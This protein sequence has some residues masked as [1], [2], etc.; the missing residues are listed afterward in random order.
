MLLPPSRVR[1]AIM[2]LRNVEDRFNRRLGYPYVLFMVEGEFEELSEIDKK[3]IEWVTEGR[4]TFAAVPHSQ[5]DV[6]ETLDHDKVE[7]SLKNIGFSHGYRAMCRF[8]SGFFWKH[9]SLAS[10]DWL[11]RLDTDIQFHCD[12]Y[13]PVQRV[14]DANAKYAFIQ[15]SYDVEWVQPS[16]A[17]NVSAFL[18]SIQ[19]A[20]HEFVWNDVPRALRGNAT[21]S[22]WTRRCM[23]NNFE[24]SHRSVWESELYTRFFTF[25]D[26]A[27]GFFYERWS[28]SPV[29]SFGVSMSLKKEE[30]VQFKD[31]G[32]QHQGWEYDCPAESSLCTC[33]REPEF[34]EFRDG[35]EGWFFP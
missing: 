7:A 15:V 6:P 11:W 29:H 10:Y 18:G 30:V 28:D 8:Y 24:I 20:N 13:D 22:Q 34:E 19:D 26:K 14:I 4:A 31:M 3:K 33:L 12:P 32:Y 1:Q 5:W 9:P 16:L 21:N 17:S 23:Y 35:G 27:G 25:L 2:A